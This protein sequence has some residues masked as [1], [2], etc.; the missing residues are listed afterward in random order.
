[1]ETQSNFDQT[2]YVLH[3]YNDCY[4][5]GNPRFNTEALD[6]FNSLNGDE[7]IRTILTVEKFGVDAVRK[8]KFTRFGL[9]LCPIEYNSGYSVEEYDGQER[10]YIDY[11]VVFKTNMENYFE[12]HDIMTGDNYKDIVH[13]SSPNNEGLIFLEFD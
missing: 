11:N 7:D 4:G 12:E 3:T 8:C 6:Y 13:K 1:M 10:P 2:K 9:C 5:G